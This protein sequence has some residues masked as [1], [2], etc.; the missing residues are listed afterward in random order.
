MKK[1]YIYTLKEAF[2]YDIGSLVLSVSM[3]DL[4]DT[5]YVYECDSKVWLLLSKSG[6]LAI[7]AGYSWDGCSPKV[8]INGRIFGVPDGPINPDTGLPRTY[9]ASLVHDALLQASADPSFPLTRQQVDQ[10]FYDILVKDGFKYAWLYYEGVKHL[11]GLYTRYISKK[12][13]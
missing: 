9:R 3:T 10:I 5:A 6:R 7:E 2:V 12:I 8:S 11:G 4:N 1:P 13:K